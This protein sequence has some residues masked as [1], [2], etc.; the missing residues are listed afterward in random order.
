MYVCTLKLYFA[1]DRYLICEGLVIVMWKS[2]TPKIFEISYNC[3]FDGRPLHGS[4][5][6][7][8]TPFIVLTIVTDMAECF[9][10]RFLDYEKACS[11]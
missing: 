1:L 5:G 9:H 7:P 3:D 8:N 2:L 6:H 4:N 10:H 11:T